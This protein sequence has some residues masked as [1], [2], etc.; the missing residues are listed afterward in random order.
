M[1]NINT[2]KTDGFEVCVDVSECDTSMSGT[3]HLQ[4]AWL[5]LDLLMSG[6]GCIFIATVLAVRRATD[7]DLM[8]CET[9]NI[10][11]DF[12][13][14]ISAC[15]CLCVQEHSVEN[16]GGSHVLSECEEFKQEQSRISRL[17]RQAQDFLNAVFH[18]KGEALKRKY[19]EYH[20]V[21]SSFKKFIKLNN[22]HRRG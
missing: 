15:L 14:F 6:I 8:S 3:C 1:V 5:V 2:I 11:L 7:S 4:I 13:S 20:G 10:A 16:G 12:C 19:V 17:E 9:R 22:V 21:S 18:R